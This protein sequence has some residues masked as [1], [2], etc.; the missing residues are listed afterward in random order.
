MSVVGHN[1]NCRP[2][3]VDRSIQYEC[4]NNGRDSAYA[5]GYM[6]AGLYCSGN[7]IGSTGYSM[8]GCDKG[9]KM[10]CVTQS[11]TQPFAKKEGLVT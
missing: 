2:Y 6:Y 10:H 5:N 8:T 3:G 9:E 1:L 4:G 7:I 11:R